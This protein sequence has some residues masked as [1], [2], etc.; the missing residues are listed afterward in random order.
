MA[1]TMK[2]TTRKS[3]RVLRKKSRRVRKQRAGGL[4]DLFTKKSNPNVKNNTNTVYYK[5]P[6][7][8]DKANAKSLRVNNNNDMNISRDPTSNPRSP[9]NS[10]NS[11]TEEPSSPV[12][13]SRSIT[14]VMG[15]SVSPTPFKATLIEG[16]TSQ[17]ATSANVIKNNI[18]KITIN[19]TPGNQEQTANVK[20]VPQLQR[21]PPSRRLLK[22]N[23][24][25]TPQV[26]TRKNRR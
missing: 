11:F 25:L 6:L 16:N 19:T 24:N 26:K 5:N 9:I 15:R 1:K 20:M 14:P 8:K 2:K 12:P 22:S 23:R 10:M 18:K 3:K 4:F 7:F 21:L 13:M 17:T